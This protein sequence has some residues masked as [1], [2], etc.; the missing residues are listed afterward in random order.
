MPDHSI[1]NIP[2]DTPIP[3]DDPDRSL[4]VIDA[5]DEQAQ[6]ISLVGD[7]YTILVS[8]KQTDGRYCLIDML[9]PEDGGPGP[10]RHDFEEMFSLLEGELEFTFRGQTQT[11]TAP[12]DVNIPADAPHAF[13]NKSGKTAHVLCMCTPAGQEEFFLAVGTLVDSRSSPAP[14]LTDDEQAALMKKM[15]ELAPKYRTEML[16]SA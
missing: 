11:V 8:G 1:V 2:A 13:T 15:K 10:H 5:D 12:H 7:T 6:H 3:P 14:E 9:I 16:K 4:T